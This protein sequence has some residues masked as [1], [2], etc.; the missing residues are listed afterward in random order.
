MSINRRSQANTAHICPLLIFAEFY[1]NS[2]YGCFI[3]L[4]NFTSCSFTNF[5]ILLR[6]DRT[7]YSIDCWSPVGCVICMYGTLSIDVMT[8][9]E[10]CRIEWVQWTSPV[11]CYSITERS[12]RSGLLAVHME[13]CT[14]YDLVRC[15]FV[16]LPIC[17]SLNW[18]HIRRRIRVP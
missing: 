11:R 9:E 2:W 17:S 13:A 18:S 7:V 8:S 14:L 4:R 5:C 16:K 15:I 1:L 10:H 6:H 3:R 12:V